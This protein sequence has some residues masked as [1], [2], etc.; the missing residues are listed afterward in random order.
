MG[1]IEPGAANVIAHNRGDGVFNVTGRQVSIRG[2]SIF[3][4]V[5]PPGPVNQFALSLGIDLGFSSG[6]NANDPGDADA[7][8]N[9]GQNFPVLTLASNSAAGLVLQGSLNSVAAQTF[10]LDFY[11]NDECDPSGNGEGQTYLGTAS[12]TTDASGNATFELTLTVAAPGNFFTATATDAAGNT[13]EF[14]ACRAVTFPVGPP[15]VAVVTST[16]DSGPGSLR[17]AILDANAAGAAI[18]RRIEFNIPGAGVHTIAA[19][20]ELPVIKRAVILDGLSQ[21]GSAAN[22]STNE[23]KPTLLIRLDGKNLPAGSDGLRIEAQDCLVQGLVFLN[24]PGD[25]I[26]LR[27]GG[28]H[29][30]TQCLL[31]WEVDAVGH[32]LPVGEALAARRPSENSLRRPLIAKQQAE[33]SGEPAPSDHRIHMKGASDTLSGFRGG[34]HLSKASS[35]GRFYP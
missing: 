30:I 5:S 16:A 2:N 35:S 18:S 26:E 4:N 24:N 12:V 17:Q 13:S 9:L 31:G 22:T 29:Q 27:G 21:P 33:P 14:C 23:F 1:G 20:T 8:A 7:G 3:G 10:T 32:P 34:Q 11:G 6:I 15:L 19:S 28:G 25:D